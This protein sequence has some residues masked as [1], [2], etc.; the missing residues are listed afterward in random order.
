MPRFF[1]MLHAKNYQNRPMF[2]GAIQKIKV[3]S[4]FLEHGVYLLNG[5]F[6]I[7]Q[8]GAGRCNK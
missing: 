3:A 5:N 4:F 8:I 2:H 1:L 6:N 7:A